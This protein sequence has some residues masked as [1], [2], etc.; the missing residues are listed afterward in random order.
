MVNSNGSHD[1]LLDCFWLN[2]KSP[3]QEPKNRLFRIDDFSLFSEHYGS[4][5]I[6]SP[7]EE[8]QVEAAKELI[9]NIM[10][11][12]KS[13]FE[14]VMRSGILSDNSYVDNVR[15]TNYYLLPTTE[16]DAITSAKEA[17]EF[18]KRGDI[19]VQTELVE[20]LGISANDLISA[21][22]DCDEN[23]AKTAKKITP[24][25]KAGT[26]LTASKVQHRIERLRTFKAEEFEQ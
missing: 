13:R 22:I 2:L 10:H 25:L 12:L 7:L 8:S 15:K 11:S 9:E 3:F 21:Y 5:R 6:L 20:K 1:F 16:I 26:A 19:W 14:V 17:E 18:K 24:M 4:P 23:C